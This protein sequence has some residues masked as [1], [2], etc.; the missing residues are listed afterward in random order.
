MNR[1]TLPHL[2][3]FGSSVLVG[4]MALGSMTPVATNLYAAEVNAPSDFTVVAKEAMPAVVSIRVKTPQKQSTFTI[5]PWGGSND[6]SQDQFGSNDMFN[7]FFGNPRR[8]SPIDRSPSIGQASGFI[9]SADGQILTN[10][11]VVQD[12]SDITVITNDGRE[13]TAKLIGADSNTDV[14]VIKIDA[15]D[16]PYL[17]FGNSDDLQVGQWVAAIGN[18]LGLQASLTVGVV[19]AKGRNNL[20]LARVEDFIQTDAAINRG[21][22]G[23][24]LLNMNGQ[25][26][27]MN[28]AIVSSEV[29]GGYMGIGFA[30]PSNLTKHVMEELLADGTASRGFM[31]VTLQPVDNNL[32]QAFGLD[33][34]EGALVADVQKDSPASKAGIKQGDIIL[35]LNGQNVTSGAGLR[36][37]VSLIK[38]GTSITLTVLRDGKTQQIKMEVGAFPDAKAT[39]AAA[40]K[41]NKLGFT[42][43]AL[44][45]EL[46]N[47][48]GL[49]GIQGVVITKID[50]NSIAAFAGIKK[51]TVILAVNQKRVSTVDEFNQELKN[52]P[53]GKPILFLIRQG[54]QTR[55]VSM[56]FG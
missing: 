22:S 6:D 26:I 50:P 37:A 49:Q 42:V 55:F 1:F 7:F 5:T 36:T 10:A 18:P 15:K 27:G 47:Q 29:G 48:L 31:G 2:H 9:V 19:S 21:N 44:T 16:L 8:Q 46:S 40:D 14:A 33:K 4:L 34:A 54:D 43:S 38:P 35:K 20:D 28:T 12:A 24:P 41:T 30:I 3:V 51:G 11:H 45:P 23:G 53:E 13:F 32:A 39:A 56:K 52:T 17:K 25:V